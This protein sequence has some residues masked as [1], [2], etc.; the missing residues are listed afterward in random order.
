MAIV[1]EYKINDVLQLTSPPELVSNFTLNSSGR[2][3]SYEYVN[4]SNYAIL[5]DDTATADGYLIIDMVTEIGKEYVVSVLPDIV[6]TPLQ[7][8]YKNRVVI[9]A[10]QIPLS[11]QGTI[12]KQELTFV[13]TEVITPLYVYA[14]DVT[15]TYSNISLKEVA[16]LITPPA[17]DP[18]V[19]MVLSDTAVIGYPDVVD[20]TQCTFKVLTQLTTEE[21]DTAE[22]DAWLACS[23]ILLD[24]G[25]VLTDDDETLTD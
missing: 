3:I 7:S 16:Q 25:V 13:A 10:V 8:Y 5:E 12:L 20:R 22:Y 18:A 2:L 11:N 17:P 23:P 21:E 4:G 15:I 14:A 19:K 6:S 24:G 9:D 1:T